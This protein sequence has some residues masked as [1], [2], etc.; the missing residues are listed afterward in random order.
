MHQDSY[1]KTEKKKREPIPIP[2]VEHASTKPSFKT[3]WK[4]KRII[5]SV[6]LSKRESL[7]SES[8]TDALSLHSNYIQNVLKRKTSYVWGVPR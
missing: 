1:L 7:E 3:K 6:R 8:E 5:R 4:R 2:I